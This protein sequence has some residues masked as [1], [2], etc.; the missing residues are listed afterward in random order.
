MKIGF[1][2]L[3]KVKID[4][5]RFDKSLH[6]SN[7][8]GVFCNATKTL[9]VLNADTVA[10]SDHGMGIIHFL[11]GENIQH[12]ISPECFSMAAKFFSDNGIAVFKAKGERVMDNIEYLNTGSLSKFNAESARQNNKCGDSCS[13][14]EGACDQFEQEV[15]SV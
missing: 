11:K 12:I 2:V 10:D 13:S 8:F 7:L 3:N 6:S 4:D 9:K 1:P 14:C 5:M 15:V